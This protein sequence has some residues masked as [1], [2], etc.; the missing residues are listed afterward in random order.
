MPKLK[1]DEKE[2]PRCAEHIKKAAKVCKHCGYEFSPA[3]I[4]AQNAADAKQKAAAGKGC[5]ILIAIVFGL[6][7]IGSIIPENEQDK[8]AAEAT[9][10]VEADKE[11]E[12]RR[13]GF[14]C[15]SAW[16]GSS[17]E[18]AEDVKSQLRDPESFEHVETR[19]TPANPE[20][21]HT[22]AM[23]YRARNGF[24]GMNA[25]T[26]IGTVRQSDC[27]ATVAAIE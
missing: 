21:L 3:E 22:V 1:P 27:S 17:R 20:G 7:V 6:F 16:D 19:I 26:A 15:L 4:E 18:F 13:K 23:Q 11:A 25:S 9:A 24:G 12:D 14:H 5:G 8:A 2:C 10:K